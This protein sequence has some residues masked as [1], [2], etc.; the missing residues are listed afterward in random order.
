MIKEK[1]RIVRELGRG[2]EGQVYLVQHKLTE[3]LR[4][5]KVLKNVPG[6]RRFQEINA[7]KRLEHPGLPQI[8][9]VIE[10]EKRIW[11]IM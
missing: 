4:A 3:Q 8:Y 10:E 7:M 2:G 11:L 9:V 1:Y 6:S 5:A